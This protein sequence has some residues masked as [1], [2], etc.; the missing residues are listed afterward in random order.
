MLAVPN[1]TLEIAID[2]EGRVLV[3]TASAVDV[4]RQ[5]G[6][7]QLADVPAAVRLE[8]SNGTLVRATDGPPVKAREP[9]AD[10]LG[11][12]KQ[13]MLEGANVVTIEELVA[14]QQVERR[15]ALL[16]RTLASMGVFVR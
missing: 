16:V 10:G 8:P 11:L 9:G 3:R 12:L 6:R 4:S 13:G 5:I 14:L 1:D 15:R 2:P 7:I